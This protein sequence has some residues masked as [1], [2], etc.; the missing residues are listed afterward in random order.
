MR[1]HEA[2][3]VNRKGPLMTN[4]SLGMFG[5]LFVLLLAASAT[6]RGTDVG[7]PC[8]IPQLTSSAYGDIKR[9][10]EHDPP[11]ITSTETLLDCLPNE[12]FAAGNLTYVMQSGSP[13]RASVSPAFPR[14]ILFGDTAETV[15]AYTG[16][17]NGPHA[18]QV[19][20]ITTAHDAPRYRFVSVTFPGDQ[21]APHIDESDER[22]VV[23]HKGHL[24]W[25]NYRD[26]D[27]AFGRNSDRVW[28]SRDREEYDAYRL[29]LRE[30]AVSPRY[31]R[32]IRSVLG[33][34]WHTMPADGEFAPRSPYVPGTGDF[35][36]KLAPAHARFV[37]ARLMESELYPSYRYLLAATFLGCSW[38]AVVEADFYNRVVAPFEGE[39]IWNEHQQYVQVLGRSPYDEVSMNLLWV[40]RL[41][42][43]GRVLGVS[44]DEWSV[45]RT[46]LRS[47][48]AFGPSFDLA[49]G[50]EIRDFVFRQ[51]IA[52]LGREVE[53]IGQAF[54]GPK[55]NPQTKYSSFLNHR[56]RSRTPAPDP[57]HAN[58][59]T[60]LL[61]LVEAE[62][63]HRAM[64]ADAAAYST[65]APER[66]PIAGS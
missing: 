66:A 12:F 18:D 51:W 32:A 43:L 48:E 24:L 45:Q 16:E 22:C 30:R 7:G 37:K 40:S 52:E 23:C 60:A 34:P 65:P 64:V 61:P 55:W 31:S 46:P 49:S 35:L 20:I 17:P 36:R 10:L 39:T 11:V 1:A 9:A 47:A 58:E 25:A 29:F 62:V 3:P 54:S 63:Y 38:N 50:I 8:P 33:D 27:G 53:V 4:R 59:C 2:E 26:W 5:C 14:T 28:Q 57:N 15:I 42:M 13:E 44:M 6:G 41:S 19:R 21:Q 56:Y